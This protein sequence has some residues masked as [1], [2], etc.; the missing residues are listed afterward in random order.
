LT[1]TR[2]NV[3]LHV[4]C[5]FVLLVFGELLVPHRWYGGKVNSNVREGFID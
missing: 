2:H 5:V 4:Q 1:R 3:T